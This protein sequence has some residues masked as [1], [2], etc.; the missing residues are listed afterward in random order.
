MRTEGRPLLL[1]NRR[2]AHFISEQKKGQF[3]VTAEGKLILPERKKKAHPY[4]T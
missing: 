2:L 3:Y 4:S 1:E